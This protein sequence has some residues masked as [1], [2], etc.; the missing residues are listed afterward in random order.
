[1]HNS[2]SD[3]KTTKMMAAYIKKKPSKSKKKAT[4]KSKGKGGY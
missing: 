4:K 2:H 1:M 3:G